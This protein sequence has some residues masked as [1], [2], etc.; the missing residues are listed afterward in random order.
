MDFEIYDIIED[1]H[2]EILPRL[3]IV[4]TNNKVGLVIEYIFWGIHIKL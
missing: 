1:A 3:A 2:L 4:I